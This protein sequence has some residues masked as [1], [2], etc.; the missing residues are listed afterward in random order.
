[1]CLRVASKWRTHL[2]QSQPKEAGHQPDVARRLDGESLSAR[3]QQRVSRPVQGVSV[4]DSGV[5]SVA[6]GHEYLY[7]V[8]REATPAPFDATALGAPT[9][10]PAAS[11]H[12]GACLANG[13][14]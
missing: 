7:D 3:V 6:R 2:D 12:C 10:E 13:D 14:R 11:L 5:E 4:L 1:V 9:D 8:L